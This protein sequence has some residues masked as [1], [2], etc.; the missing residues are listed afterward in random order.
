MSNVLFKRFKKFN[1]FKTLEFHSEK[2][3]EQIER[4]QPIKQIF[5]VRNVPFRRHC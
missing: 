2:P 3:F 1:E 5:C 4:I